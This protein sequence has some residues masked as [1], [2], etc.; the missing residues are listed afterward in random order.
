MNTRNRVVLCS[1]SL[2][3]CA[4]GSNADEIQDRQAYMQYDVRN[5]KAPITQD[6]AAKHAK[7]LNRQGVAEFRL[8]SISG[9]KA[10]G[11]SFKATA[12]SRD[13][14]AKLRR[15]YIVPEVDLVTQ[16]GERMRI[17]DVVNG[18][19]P[20]ILNFIFVTCTTICPVLSA[21]FA[22]VQDMLG[23]EK[24]DIAMVSITIDPEYDTPDRLLEY[25][26][27]FNAG[28]QWLFLTGKRDDIVAVEKA[29]DIYRGSKVNHEPITLIRT[30]ADEPWL[31]LEGIANASDI[32][33]EYHSLLSK[34]KSQQ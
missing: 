11:N 31:R 12:A 26:K 19:K 28:P 34:G 2:L 7:Y 29:F 15:R 3:L 30:A 25:S 22:S 20:V 14:Y 32:V 5:L 1:W 18:G 23:D 16:K 27:R 24:D 9:D 8:A 10:H 6:C 21:S 17:A 33:A 13:G 4:F